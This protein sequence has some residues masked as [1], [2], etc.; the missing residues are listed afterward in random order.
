MPFLH[1]GGWGVTS[2]DSILQLTPLLQPFV[3]PA[4]GTLYA[5]QNASKLAKESHSLDIDAELR[6]GKI[7]VGLYHTAG[8]CVYVDPPRSNRHTINPSLA[9]GRT[10]LQGKARGWR[11]CPGQKTTTSR[12]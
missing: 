5:Y 7:S 11:R 2:V 4:L 3:W 10:H 1:L 8:T 6:A 12:G 9:L